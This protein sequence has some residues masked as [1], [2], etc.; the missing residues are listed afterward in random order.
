MNTMYDESGRSAWECCSIEE[1]AELGLLS[2][3]DLEELFGGWDEG[4]E[5]DAATMA[6]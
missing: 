6:A 2:E 5:A 4:I 3:A 1:L